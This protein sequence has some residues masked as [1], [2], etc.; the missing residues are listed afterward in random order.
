MEN[1]LYTFNN[2][3]H[4]E[5]HL[6]EHM[7]KR[8]ITRNAL[9]RAVNTRFELADSHFLFYTLYLSKS[10]YFKRTLMESN[11]LYYVYFYVIIIM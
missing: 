4:V 3:G 2:Y 6:K 1:T 7:D 9:A 11:C 10:Q 8:G 5:I